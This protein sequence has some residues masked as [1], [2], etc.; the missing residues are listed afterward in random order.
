MSLNVH[1]IIGICLILFALYWF[2]S[3]PSAKPIKETRGWLAGRWYTLLTLP[4]FLLVVDFRF[5]GRLGVPVDLLATPMISPGALGGVLSVL[6]AVAGLAIAIAARRTLGGNWSG[7]VAIKTDH[8]LVTTGLYRYVRHPIYTGILTMMIGA[9]ISF[10]TVGAC[11][12][13]PLVALSLVLKLRDEERV[14]AQYFPNDYPAYKQ[15]TRAIIPFI[16]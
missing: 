2:V 15:R 14:L 16:W 13:L 5:L 6:L 9:A 4:G 10:G 7:S 11:I 12:G 8:E 1:Q 3:A